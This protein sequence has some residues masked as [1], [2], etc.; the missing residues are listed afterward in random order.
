VKKSNKPIPT[1]ANETFTVDQ[2]RLMLLTGGRQRLDALIG[3]IDGAKTSL[4]LLYYIYADD[5]A[6]RAVRDALARALE[7]GV[8]VALIVDGFGSSASPEFFA[9]IEAEAPISAVSCP[10]SGVA[11]CCATTRNSSSPTMRSRSSAA[12]TSRMI[13]STTKTAGAISACTSPGPRR[14]A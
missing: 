8:T 5:D 10:I 4:R 12:S 9:S 6:G 14:H 1:Q 2:N 13:I 11:T 7:R 3:L